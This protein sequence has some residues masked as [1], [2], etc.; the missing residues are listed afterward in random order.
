MVW[1]NS[2]I[3][4]H[5]F[6]S[7]KCSGKREKSELVESLTKTFDSKCF[8]PYSYYNSSCSMSTWLTWFETFY[9]KNCKFENTIRTFLASGQAI[10]NN[11][12]GTTIKMPHKS[13]QIIKMIHLYVYNEK[14][15]AQIDSTKSNIILL[16]DTI[17][18]DRR[19]KYWWFSL[20]KPKCDKFNK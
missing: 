19:R 17:T 13:N 9:L 10:I 7:W 14:Q 5:F 6:R 8:W 11:I 12:K 16:I 1:N 4:S 18:M 20:L 15:M 2:G 3:V